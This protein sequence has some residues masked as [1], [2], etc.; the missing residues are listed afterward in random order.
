MAKSRGKAAKDPIT[1][2]TPMREGFAQDLA[3]GMSQIEAYKKNFNVTTD[4]VTT[5]QP[6]A[7]KTAHDPAV[8]K[9]VRELQAEAE[10]GAILDRK[11]RQALLTRF[12]ID[13]DVSNS[14]RLSALDKLNKMSGDYSETIRNEISGGLDVKVERH[15]VIKSLLKECGIDSNG[16]S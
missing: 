6:N 3:N 1:G 9:R 14:D 15:N 5:T 10:K 7:W 8:M 2:L 16:E 13:E 4:K 11:A 12:A